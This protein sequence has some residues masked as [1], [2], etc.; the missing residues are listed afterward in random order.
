M[1]GFSDHTDFTAVEATPI[2]RCRINGK[3]DGIRI[4]DLVDEDIQLEAEYHN[5]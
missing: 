5:L 1:W 4:W 3:K 2:E